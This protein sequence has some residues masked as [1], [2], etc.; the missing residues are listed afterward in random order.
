MDVTSSWVAT[1]TPTPDERWWRK[2]SFG[3]GDGRRE[4]IC[5]QSLFEIP[6][7]LEARVFLST[8]C[9]SLIHGKLILTKR[10]RHRSCVSSFAKHAA[11][12]QLRYKEQATKQC[13]PSSFDKRAAVLQR[14][15]YGMF[16][17]V[18]SHLMVTEA[19]EF[20][21]SLKRQEPAQD[22]RWRMIAGTDRADRGWGSDLSS[23]VECLSSVSGRPIIYSQAIWLLSKPHLKVYPS[24]IREL[25]CSRRRTSLHP[26]LSGNV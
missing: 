23:A 21:F 16:M 2:H 7:M 26:L 14:P 24:E 10:H 6:N 4:K 19:L 11:S 8:A 15:G 18:T 13:P 25:P 20:S 22:S 12:A 9:T 1:L 3:G 5:L 17:Q